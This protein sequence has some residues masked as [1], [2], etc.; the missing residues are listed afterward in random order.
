[1]VPG[2]I[3]LGALL[4]IGFVVGAGADLSHPSPHSLNGRDVAAQIALGIQAEKGI[5]NL[6]AV[7]C[8]PSEPVRQGL[9]FRCS[10]SA[11]PSK[12]AT[13]VQVTEIDGRGHLRWQPVP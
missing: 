9:S 6:P 13:T 12:A 1:L 2:L 3:A 7:N 10:V 4:A 11:L 8:P 5:T